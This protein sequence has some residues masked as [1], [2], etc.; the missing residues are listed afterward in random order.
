[1]SKHRRLASMHQVM[2]AGFYLFML[3][4]LVADLFLPSWWR[5]A[6]AVRPATYAAIPSIADTDVAIK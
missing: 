6:E 3:I 1:M 2:R 5:L 4:I